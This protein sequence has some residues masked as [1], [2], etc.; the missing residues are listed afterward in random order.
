MQKIEPDMIEQRME[1]FP[2]W[3]N[4]GQVI[5]RTFVFDNFAGSMDFVHQVA[6]LA[7]RLQHHPDIMIRYAKVT[8]TLTTHEAGGITENDFTFA[9][10]VDSMIGVRSGS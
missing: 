9:R 7:E 1:Q 3:S 2:E 6:E 4:T 5:Q 8:L 10:E